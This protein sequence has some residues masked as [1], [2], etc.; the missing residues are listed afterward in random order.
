M[1]K[2]TMPDGKRR[3]KYSKTQ[4]EVKDWLLSERGKLSQGTYIRDEKMTVEAFLNQYLE[5]YGKNSLRATTLH[6]YTEIIEK[7]IIPEIGNLKLSQLRG[8][9][10]NHLYSKKLSSKLSNRT[11]EYIHGILR[12]ALN[13]AVKWGLL[14][15][16]PTDMAS[17][18]SVKFKQPSVWSSEQVKVFLEHVKDD[19]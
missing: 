17:P 12:R 3:T 18:P 8:D 9:H 4:K 10:L 15:K 13:K 2:L 16:N 7:H 5:D 14:S 11:V 6:S 1:G 19:R